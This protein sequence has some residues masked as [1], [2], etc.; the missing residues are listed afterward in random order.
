MTAVGIDVGGRRKGF[1]GCAVRGREIVAGPT[2]LD[3]VATAVEWVVGLEPTTV[4]VDSPCEGAPAGTKSRPDEHDFFDA[5]ICHIRWTPAVE[6]FD[7][8]PSYYEW[9]VH[10]FELYDALAERLPSA[11]LIETFPTAAW[12][13]WAGKR[14]K[15]SRAKTTATRSPPL[16]SHSFMTKAPRCAASASSSFPPTVLSRDDEELEPVRHRPLQARVDQGR[17]GGD[18]DPVLLDPR[19]F[20]DLDNPVELAQRLDHP[21]AADPGGDETWF[22]CKARFPHLLEIAF[23]EIPE[24][25]HWTKDR[26]GQAPKPRTRR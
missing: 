25:G 18:D 22:R 20:E 1:H 24:T 2:R 6:S 13:S 5:K 21:L 26:C 3:D 15:R 8:N 17:V 7:L 11:D 4:A 9:I 10:G 16:S 12:T 19:R 23:P 14:K